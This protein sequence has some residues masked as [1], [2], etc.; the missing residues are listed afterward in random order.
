MCGRNFEYFGEDPFLSA[1]LAKA[2]VNGVQSKNV[3]NTVKH[4]AGN[5][6]EW[7]RYD[8]SSDIDERTLPKYIFLPL[9][10]LLLK[11]MQELL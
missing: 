3:V 1:S 4:F 6:Q 10:Q 8:V 11:L 7:D 5:N 2:Y 9:R